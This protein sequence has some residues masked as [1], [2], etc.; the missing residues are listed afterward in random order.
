MSFNDTFLK[1]CRGEK[2]DHTPIWLMRQAGRY[3]KEY[4]KIKEKHSMIDICNNSDLMTEITLLPIQQFNFD[5][6]IIF[7]DIMI[8]LAPMGIDFD[9]KAGVGP[10]VGNPIRSAKDVENLKSFDPA[11]SLTETGK[12]L[13]NLKQ[14][15]N[16]PCIGFV[17]APF[18]L[19]SYMIEG[20]PS[21]S[22]IKLKSFMYNE[23]EAWN[24]LMDKLAYS[25]A[26]YLNYQI[27]CGASAVQIFDSWIGLLSKEDYWD[28]VFPHM[29]TMI[30]L[31]K[32]ENKETP[33]ILF[34]TNTSHLLDQFQNANPDVIGIDWKTSLPEARNAIKSN[35]ALQGK[36][37]PTSLFA[38]WDIIEEKTRDILDSID[39]KKG[40]IFN[41]GHGILPGTPVENVKRLSEFV[42]NY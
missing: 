2:T 1:A 24:A 15:L 8:P 37:D 20:G 25:M 27:E 30:S 33:V 19:A 22:H 17:G 16:V 3:Q 6:A 31:I 4:R 42:R 38:S 35:I 32:K 34:G 40:F 14:E 10:V 26:N 13:K 18:T 41:L 11:E 9:Y 5:A 12:A 39:T 28:Y 36:L 29:K 23:K 7:S 21:K